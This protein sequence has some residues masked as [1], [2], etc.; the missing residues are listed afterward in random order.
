MAAFSG[1]RIP[2]PIARWLAGKSP[3]ERRVVTGLLTAAIAALAWAVLWQPVI[4]DADALRDARDGNATA[5]A[6]ARKMV[7]ESAGLARTSA[8]PAKADARAGLE[9]VLVQQGLRPAVTQ[10]DWQDGRARVVFA[11]V[12]YD[13]LIATLETLQRD[14]RLRVAEATITSR[15]EPGMVRAEVTLAR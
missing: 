4:R 1:M 2:A 11:A 9:R 6:S 3:G 14:E 8:A 13:A 5:L 10:L 15:V 7:E 12:G